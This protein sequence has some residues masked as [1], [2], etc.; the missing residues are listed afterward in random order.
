VKEVGVRWKDDGDSRLDLIAGNWRNAMDILKIGLRR[1]KVPPAVD[2]E[3]T[4]TDGIA[5]SV[6][7]PSGRSL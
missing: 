7:S 3:D 5:T 4:T 2:F 6:S 1:F